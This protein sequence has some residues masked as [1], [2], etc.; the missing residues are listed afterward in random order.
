M[1]RKDND[2]LI[3]DV[4]N[5][6][7]KA[8]RFDGLGR[9]V[10]RTV[11]AHGDH[12]P[13]RALFPDAPP[14]MIG[15]GSVAGAAAEHW[16]SLARWAPLVELRGDGPSPLRNAYGTPATLGVDRLANAVA[17]YTAFP[18]RN[19]LAIDAGT[20][21]TYDLVAAD[22]RYLGGAI[23]PGLAM[24]AK[25][26][27]AYSARL[28]LVQDLDE[29]PT[30]GTDTRSGLAAGVLYGAVFEAA[31]FRADWGQQWP[32]PAVVITGGDGPRIMRG[33]KSGIF[34]HPDL[35]LEGLH[36]L[37]THAGALR[38]TGVQHHG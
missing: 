1:P 28:P 2:V 3:I 15:W 8:A 17:A 26:M 18:G 12:G 19:V 5:T 24:R 9:V 13:L 35:T 16:A 37:L 21:I 30:L 29:V 10:A 38:D 31:G 11:A 25:A 4:G 32:D 22:G 23:T 20:C 14:A 27:H 34:A 7:M 36:V 33:L 6:R